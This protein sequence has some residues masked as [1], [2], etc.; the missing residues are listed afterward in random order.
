[1]VQKKKKTRLHT[2]GRRQSFNSF[3][4][5]VNRLHMFRKKKTRFVYRIPLIRIYDDDNYCNLYVAGKKKM[6][7]ENNK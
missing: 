7:E 6:K 3:V 2:N 1:M 5:R 4:T